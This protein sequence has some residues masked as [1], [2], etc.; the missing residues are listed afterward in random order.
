[1]DV[2]RI[3]DGDRSGC[4]PQER[5]VARGEEEPYWVRIDAPLLAVDA[6]LTCSFTI[7]DSYFTIA[8]LGDDNSEVPVRQQ[9][10][11]NDD[12]QVGLRA[13]VKAQRRAELA[14]EEA[15]LFA[16]EPLEVSADDGAASLSSKL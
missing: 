16:L 13:V 8:N 2:Q 5:E 1:L 9:L 15:E 6:H 4:F 3:A 12:D 7:V 10:S 11:V 14:E